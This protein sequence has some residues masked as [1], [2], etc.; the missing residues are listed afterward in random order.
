MKIK[1]GAMDSGNVDIRHDR[2]FMEYLGGE[3]GLLNLQK[4]AGQEYVK[5]CPCCTG[6][7][8]LKLSLAYSG[9]LVRISCID[10]GIQTK[11]RLT[12]KN[13]VTGKTD[14]AIDMMEKELAVWNHRT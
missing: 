11:G 6:E 2:Y 8:E 5:P 4:Q 14:T 1:F 3:S 10:C 12:G 9:L 7:A 13:I